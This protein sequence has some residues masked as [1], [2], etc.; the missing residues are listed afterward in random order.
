MGCGGHYAVSALRLCGEHEST[1]WAEK[2][3]SF[4]QIRLMP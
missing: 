2:E 1:H 3:Q 4:V